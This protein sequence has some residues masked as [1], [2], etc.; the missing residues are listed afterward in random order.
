MP[1][2]ME[3]KTKGLCFLNSKEMDKNYQKKKKKKAKRLKNS[4]VTL[5]P[6][7]FEGE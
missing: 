6:V 1:T 7:A 4:S 5:L 2:A 3:A